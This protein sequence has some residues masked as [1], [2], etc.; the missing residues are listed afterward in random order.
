MAPAR[1]VGIVLLVLG[2]VLLVIG[3]NASDSIADQLSDTFTGKFTQSTS[4]YILGGGAMTLLGALM[5][6]LPLGKLRT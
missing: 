1:I 3:L 6:F 2:L 4:W 5:A